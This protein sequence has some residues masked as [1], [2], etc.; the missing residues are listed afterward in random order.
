MLEKDPF[1][2]TKQYKEL[3]PENYLEYCLSLLDSEQR[4]F[5][6]ENSLELPRIQ[7][8]R[9]TSRTKEEQEKRNYRFLYLNEV[10]VKEKH[11][12]DDES[13]QRS[14]PFLYQQYI[15]KESAQLKQKDVSYSFLFL[16]ILFSLFF[17]TIFRNVCIDIFRY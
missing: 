1:S 6:A 5:V 15:E 9:K 13:I 10:L 17:F 3:L 8:V 12:F 11:Y 2:F 7:Q 14:F 4:A 16:F